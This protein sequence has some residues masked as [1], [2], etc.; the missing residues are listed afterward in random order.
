[1]ELSIERLSVDDVYTLQEISVLT[2]RAAFLHLN[3]ANNFEAYLSDKKSIH[4]LTT[5]LKNPNSHFF[6]VYD[7]ED[8]VA[9]LKYNIGVAQSETFPE[10][11]MELERIYV[12]PDFQGRGYGAYLLRHAEQYAL[13]HGCT[14]LWLGVWEYNPDAIRFY[15]RH[16][17]RRIGQHNFTIGNEE[18]TDYIYLKELKQEDNSSF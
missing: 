15:E 13:D 4:Q 6:Y 3:D 16:G 2:M 1:M 17:M 18:Q 5:E 14:A 11:H 12:L 7:G 9:Y 10:D 8:R